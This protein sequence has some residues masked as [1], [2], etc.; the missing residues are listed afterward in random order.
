MFE[1]LKD[2]VKRIITSRL[3]ALAV[4]MVCL[5]AVLLQRIFVLQIVNGQDYADKY[6]LML[7]KERTTNGA[8]GVIY[9]RNG[10]PLAYNELAYTVTLEDSGFY[11]SDEVRNQKLNAEIHEIIQILASNGDAISNSFSIQMDD[12]GGLAYSVRGTNLKRFLADVYGYPK[13]EDL[14]KNRNKL[15]YEEG[16]ATPEQVFDFLRSDKKFGIRIQGVDEPTEE[17]REAGQPFYSMAEAYQIL[18]VRYALSQ[19]AYQ[20]YIQTTVATD[21]SEESVAAIKE[22]SDHLTGVEISEDTIRRYTDSVYFSHLIGWTGKISQEEY[23]D[24][25]QKNDNY[26][27]TDIVGKSGIEK[28]M[29]TVLQGSKG[30]EIFYKDNMGHILEMRDYVE[31]VSGDNVYLSID[32]DL[33]IAVYKL[34]EQ[35]IAGIVYSK[36]RNVKEYSGGSSEDD[37]IIPI[38]DVY[39]AL[40]NNNL[41]DFEAFS[42][43]GASPTE[44]EIYQRFSE[45]LSEVIAGL[46]AQMN[47]PA[48]LSYEK[49]SEEYQAYTNYILS[50]LIKN[51]ALVDKNIDTE[52]DVYLRWKEEK[53]SLAEYLQHAIAKEWIDITKFE[54]DSKY[55]DSYEI[56]EALMQYI[57]DQARGDRDFHKKIYK[58]MIRDNAIEGRQICLILYEQE[59][60][61]YDEANYQALTDGSQSA[62]Q[63]LR[64]RIKSLDITPGQ[65]ALDPC[66][67]S[68]VVINSQTGEVLACVSYPGYDTNRLAN[69]MD[70]NYYRRLQDDLTSP[71]YS[72]ATQQETAPGSTFKMVTAAAGLTEGLI[73]TAIKIEDKGQFELVQNGPKCWIY[74]GGT[75]GQ[76]NVSEAIRD[77]CNYFFYTLGYNMS[78]VGE[79]Y[80]EN[81]GINT[82]TKYASMFGLGQ[83]TGV[84]VPENEPKISD[85]YPITSAIGQ[86]AHNYTTIGLARYAAAIASSG[87]VYQLTLLDKVTDN[88]GT[89]IKDYGPKVIDAMTG[90]SSSTWDAIHSGMRMVV[91]ESKVFQ[92]FPE[93]LTVAGKSGTAQQLTTRPNHALF[94][95]YAPYEQPQIAIATRIAHGYSSNNAV[96]AS[97]HILEYYFKLKEPEALLTGQAQDVGDN[98][99]SF[100]D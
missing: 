11:P 72:N 86:G 80:Q 38:D 39:F 47:D 25:S 65:L 7:E 64:E 27:L 26:T 6:T 52:D 2:F 19:N 58:Y 91:Q 81:L 78:L 18:T 41:I 83:K 29:E 3:F 43:P 96:E 32:H 51:E 33:Q 71:M 4:A 82:L 10:V 56:Y 55:S 85:K 98:A 42:A 49:L 97:K 24:L 14:A 22:N 21:I 16:E 13:V 40:F 68:S 31:A 48:P 23:D 70:N 15:G 75:H 87:K 20:V 88:D 89:L 73:D 45:K 99:N 84:E 90:L 95:G 57:Q 94:V 28:E 53:I 46:T 30:R 61:A 44:Q 92:D 37:I 9:D 5:F 100:T 74:P 76:I 69:N 1:A 62:F 50:M 60:L 77:S 93:Q 36:I 67:G 17:E 54:T 66:T 59:I 34:L 8:R 63:F 35:E 79:K 12:A